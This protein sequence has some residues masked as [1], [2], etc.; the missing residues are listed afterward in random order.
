MVEGACARCSNE[1]CSEN[2]GVAIV[3][4]G[5]SQKKYYDL[6]VDGLGAAV[7]G[8]NIETKTRNSSGDFEIVVTPK[9]PKAAEMILHVADKDFVFL[10]LG[11]GTTFEIP[12]SGGFNLPYGQLKQIAMFAAAVAAGKFEE[13]LVFI[14]DKIIGGT[15]TVHFPEKPVSITH[16]QLRIPF[17]HKTREEHFQYEPYVE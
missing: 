4:E 16:T 13:S 12:G 7:A 6:L 1:R 3:S 15:G 14:G 17:L 8:A 2:Y 9:N 5:V 10:Y 11:R